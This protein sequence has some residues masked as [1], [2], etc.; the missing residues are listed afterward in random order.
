MA[1]S[2]AAK[3][4]VYLRRAYQEFGLHD[5][6]PLSLA[7]D[8]RAAI[9]VSYNPQHHD[10]IKHI[11]RRHFFV[12]EC[13]EDAQITVPYVRTT[14]NLADFFTKALPAPQFVAMR[15][16]IM[17]IDS[18]AERRARK[19]S[20]LSHGGALGRGQPDVTRSASGQ[21]TRCSLLG[22]QAPT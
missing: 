18:E 21:A 10:R 7:S 17:N 3:E 8:N 6:S 15:D 1:C 2:E 19:C 14:D 5:E 4:G 12:R 13:V 11:E 22:G 16:I 9:D 20:E